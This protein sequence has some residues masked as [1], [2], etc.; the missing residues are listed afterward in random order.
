MEEALGGRGRE[1]RPFLEAGT[2]LFFELP[3]AARLRLTYLVRGASWHP[4]Y[5][6]RVAP[7]LT[8]VTVGL[9]A[10]LAQSTDEDWEDAEI[11]LS[12]SRPS[13]RKSCRKGTEPL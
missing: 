2:S 8:G 6:V 10:E 7:D 12:T 9:V 11:L 1:T 13:L 5:D 4:A 3:G